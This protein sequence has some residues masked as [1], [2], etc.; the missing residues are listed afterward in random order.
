MTSIIFDIPAA[1]LPYKLRFLAVSPA[2]AVTVTLT[3]AGASHVVKSITPPDGEGPLRWTWILRADAESYFGPS[4]TDVGPAATVALDGEHGPLVVVESVVGF[5]VDSFGTAHRETRL[6]LTRETA[7]SLGFPAREIPVEMVPIDLRVGQF[8]DYDETGQFLTG[9]TRS[10][11]EEAMDAALILGGAHADIVDGGNTYEENEASVRVFLPPQSLEEFLENSD[12]GVE[13]S[14]DE[15]T[16]E[17]VS[18]PSEAD[19]AGAKRRVDALAKEVT[20]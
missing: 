19:V 4:P 1:R 2:G 16:T 9:R 17:L 13:M 14:W 7:L 12:V 8:W 18:L 3:D 6:I 11:L 15:G 20:P 10:D 5:E